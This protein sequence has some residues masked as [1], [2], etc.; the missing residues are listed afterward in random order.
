[1]GGQGKARAMCDGR[2]AMARVHSSCMR[3]QQGSLTSSL[4]SVWR[5][6]RPTKMVASSFS[7]WERASKREAMGQQ[8]QKGGEV[9]MLKTSLR[10]PL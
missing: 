5:G 4:G 10:I 6:R 3:C 8:E 2:V 1:M 9:R 7:T